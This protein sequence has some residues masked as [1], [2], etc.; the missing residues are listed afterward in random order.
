MSDTLTITEAPAAEATPIIELPPVVAE[1]QAAAEAAGLT[2]AVRGETN[3]RWAVYDAAVPSDERDELWLAW[4]PGRRFHRGTVLA[5]RYSSVLTR[6][7][8]EH[9]VR[10]PLRF[11]TETVLPRLRRATVTS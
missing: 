9:L 4:V 2:F 5:H 10:V 3:T 6:R 8:R 7:S 1:F 11:A